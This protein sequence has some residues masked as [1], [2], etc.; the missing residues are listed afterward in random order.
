MLFGSLGPDRMRLGIK[1]KQACFVLLSAF[2]IV[3]LA[4]ASV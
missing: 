3:T 2:T 4:G 1:N